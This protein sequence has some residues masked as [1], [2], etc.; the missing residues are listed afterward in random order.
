MASDDRTCGERVK[1]GVPELQVE[2]GEYAVERWKGRNCS[3][4]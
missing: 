2:A 3:T 1:G 4:E